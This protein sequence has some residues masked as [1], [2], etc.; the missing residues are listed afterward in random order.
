MSVP[1]TAPRLWRPVLVY[2][3][4]I[5][6][7]SSIADTPALPGNTD[8]GAHALLYAGLG[9]LIVRALAGGWGAPV[10]AVM[11]VAATVLAGGYGIT[12]ELHQYFVPP[13][14]AD[15]HDVMA[16]VI[17]AGLASLGLYVWSMM[18]DRGL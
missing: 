7:I 3:V 1:S 5:F 8:K 12:D 14:Q 11:V 6:A 2:M 16:D 4:F 9:A 17:G 10:T 18:S 15:V 13:R